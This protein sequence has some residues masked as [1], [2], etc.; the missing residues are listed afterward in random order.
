MELRPVKRVSTPRVYTADANGHR[1]AGRADGGELAVGVRFER[2]DAATGEAFELRVTTAEL[3]A[4]LEYAVAVEVS[5]DGIGLERYQ[6]PDPDRVLHAMIERV[7]DRAATDVAIA[8]R[9]RR[10]NRGT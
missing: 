3:L 4:L 1:A 6:R 8:E 5:L 2:A 10:L 7:K 9:V